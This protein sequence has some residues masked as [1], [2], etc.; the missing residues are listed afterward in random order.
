MLIE[1]CCSDSSALSEEVPFG[2]ATLRITETIDLTHFK[3]HRVI[4][5]IRRYAKRCGVRVGTWISIPCTAG[6][7]WRYINARK[8]IATGDIVL[9]NKL[10]DRCVSF[11]NAVKNDGGYVVWEWPSRCDLWK[12][13]RVRALTSHP[14][15]NFVDVSSSAVDWNMVVNGRKIYLSKKWRLFTTERDIAKVL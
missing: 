12:D 11:A 2:C 13:P 15:G 10:I 9:T 6:C 7:P 1:R 3:T 8:G 5:E 4:N 14:G